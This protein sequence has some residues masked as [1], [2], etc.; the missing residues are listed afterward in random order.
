MDVI[1][2][3]DSPIKEISSNS[4]SEFKGSLFTEE[5][6]YLFK[7]GNHFRLYNHLGAHLVNFNGEEGTCFSV[8][9]PNAKSVSVVGDFNG[10][11]NQTN[12]LSPRWDSS[13]IWEGFVPGVKRGAL[14]KYYIV[15]NYNNYQ[16][17]DLLPLK[18]SGHN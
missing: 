16:T 5:D 13:G 12:F 10:W 3:T 18:Q 15:S 9:A 2:N 1:E 14:Y 17:A 11:N 7:Q 6:V 4:I 8:W